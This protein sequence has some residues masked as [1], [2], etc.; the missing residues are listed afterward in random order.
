MCNQG[1]DDLHYA[2]VD[3]HTM[4]VL[5]AAQHS[6]RCFH[7][8]PQQELGKVLPH[9]TIDNQQE[10]AALS[11]AFARLMTPLEEILGSLMMSAL[12]L[13]GAV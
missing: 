7:G 11:I 4:I 12:R 13:L 1:T 3:V 5:I 8:H 2:A 9:G 10:L 6:L